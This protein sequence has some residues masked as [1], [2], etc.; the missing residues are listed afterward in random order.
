MAARILN[1]IVVIMCSLVVAIMRFLQ[2]S[3][4]AGDILPIVDLGRS[5][6]ENLRQ[7][8]GI[9]FDIL[10]EVVRV[11]IAWRKPIRIEGQGHPQGRRK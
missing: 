2:R 1:L 3:A 4:M 11:I 8:S 7:N 6:W 9:L 5:T 10:E